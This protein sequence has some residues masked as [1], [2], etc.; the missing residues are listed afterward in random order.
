MVRLKKEGYIW[1]IDLPQD[2][3]LPLYK[4]Y[5]LLNR[6]FFNCFNSVHLVTVV[7]KEG[8]PD[9]RVGPLANQLGLKSVYLFDIVGRRSKVLEGQYLVFF[10]VL[11]FLVR[12]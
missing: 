4:I 3:K 9:L 2:I 12:A 6:L 1:M 10:F 8:L 5:V 11:C 7:S